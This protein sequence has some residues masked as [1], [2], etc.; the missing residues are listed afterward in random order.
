ME[1]VILALS[2][3]TMLLLTRKIETKKNGQL[4]RVVYEANQ[5]LWQSLSRNSWQICYSVCEKFCYDFE[6]V[7]FTWLD[8]L[9]IKWI[10]N[11]SGRQPSRQIITAWIK[12]KHNPLYLSICLKFCLSIKKLIHHDKKMDNSRTL[13]THKL[14]Y[15]RRLNTFDL[16]SYKNL[17]LVRSKNISYLF[18]LFD[19]FI[20]F[21]FVSF[22][23]VN[24]PPSDYKSPNKCI[25]KKLS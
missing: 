23:Q 24:Q 8:L 4:L 21:S 3:W 9:R 16:W 20:S 6:H 17:I 19:F 14:D 11:M 10:A 18:V 25:F 1:L 5:I 7:W 2:N 15:T 22:Q 12:Y 13:S